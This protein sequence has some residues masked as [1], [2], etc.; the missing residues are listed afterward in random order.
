[1]RKPSSFSATLIAAA[2][3]SVSAV[4]MSALADPDSSGG[5]GSPFSLDQIAAG[6]KKAIGR[7]FAAN[8]IEYGLDN[9]MEIAFHGQADFTPPP[10][11]SIPFA[12]LASCLNAHSGHIFV[13]D[14]EGRMVFSDRTG[15]QRRVEAKDVNGDGVKELIS[16]DSSGGTGFSSV[17]GRYYFFDGV[18]FHKGLEYEKSYYETLPGSTIFPGAP[19]LRQEVWA[20]KETKGEVRFL[21]ADLDGFS[22]LATVSY[23]TNYSIQDYNKDRDPDGSV[24]AKVSEAV[25]DVFGEQL[26]V[27]KNHSVIWEWDTVSHTYL[28]Q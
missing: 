18:R 19:D 21:D 16:T 17:W 1:M 26:G 12:W 22:E 24:L 4:L 9:F 2:I 25:K 23:T 13:I 27:E 11:S 5:G 20:L 3:F 15:C 8:Q 10:E 6:D 14:R 28:K 7:F